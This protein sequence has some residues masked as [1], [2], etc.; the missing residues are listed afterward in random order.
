MG[1]WILELAACLGYSCNSQYIRI[2]LQRFK[3][4]HFKWNTLIVKRDILKHYKGANLRTYLCKAILFAF[5]NL[6]KVTVSFV[7]SVR[8]SVLPSVYPSAWNNWAVN[9]W[10]CMKFNIWIRLPKYVTKVQE[11]L[12]SVKITGILHEDWY[13]FLIISRSFVLRMRNVA[14]KSC[15][16]IQNTRFMFNNC[17]WKIVHF[18]R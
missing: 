12:K 13:T 10:V 2:R 3:W 18:M 7:M 16:E 6:W 5:E 17:F 15:R 11:S 9:R 8:L 1:F 4:R 14:D